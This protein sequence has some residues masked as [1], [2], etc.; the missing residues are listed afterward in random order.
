[1]QD[2]VNKFKRKKPLFLYISSLPL[3]GR[4]KIMHS[5]GKAGFMS[6][7]TVSGPVMDDYDKIFPESRKI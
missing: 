5:G 7:I 4:I 6:F 2:Y 3:V 1:M